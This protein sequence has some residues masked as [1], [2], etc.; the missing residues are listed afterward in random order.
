MLGTVGSSAYIGSTDFDE[1]RAQLVA[2]DGL[3]LLVDLIADGFIVLGVLHH[4]F[5]HDADA[6]AFERL[7]R[8][9]PVFHERSWRRAP[10]E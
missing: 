4:E 9:R 3:D 7:R 8:H 5:A 6:H 2:Q 1:F 10:L